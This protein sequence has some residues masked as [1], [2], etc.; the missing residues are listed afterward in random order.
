MAYELVIGNKNYSSWSLRAWLLLRFVGVPFIEHRI[1]LYQP[2]AREKV[3]GFGGETGLVPV[4]VDDGFPIWD[5]LAITEHLYD[6]YP[7]IWPAEKHDRARARSHSGEVHSSLNALRAAMPI[8][9]RGR[10]RLAA[11]TPDVLADIER[12]KAIWTKSGARASSPWLFDY[13]CAA[14][15]MFA[16]VALR[17]QTYDVSM[18]GKAGAYLEALLAHPLMR[19]WCDLAE[20]EEDIIPQFELPEAIS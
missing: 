14:D 12:V 15:V 3:Q 1:N 7:Q 16:P 20:E 11:R 10:R 18:D 9:A 6:S 2:G 13:F 5:T 17:F 19:E 8:N 4:L